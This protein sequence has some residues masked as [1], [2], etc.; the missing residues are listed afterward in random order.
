M[1]R[2]GR[3]RGSDRDKNLVG[4]VLAGVRYAVEIPKVREIIRPL[5]LVPIPH[6]PF[7]VI[8]VADHRNEVIPVLDLRVRFGL[9]PSEDASRGKW[10]VVTVG[11]RSVGLAVD[12]VTEVFAAGDEDLRV[13]PALA[14]GDE[15][16]GISHVY[17]VK[18]ALVFVVDVEQLASQAA[19]VEMSRLDAQALLLEG[20][21]P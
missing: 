8:G 16:R 3:R 2:R 10:L 13:A 20:R 7:A 17:G 1:N 5:A 18:G 6:P 21:E 9:P 19:L 11:T 14:G 4:F 15:A 12:A